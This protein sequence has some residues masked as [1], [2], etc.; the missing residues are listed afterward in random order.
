M[1][2]RTFKDVT[3]EQMTELGLSGLPSGPELADTLAA[4]IADVFQVSKQ[5]GLIRLGTLRIV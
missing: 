5:A 3:F 4:A 2:G 1:P